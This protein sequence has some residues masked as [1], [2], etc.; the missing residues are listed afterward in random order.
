MVAISCCSVLSWYGIIP[1][2]Y[3]GLA[4]CFALSVSGVTGEILRLELGVLRVW[5]F[6]ATCLRCVLVVCVCVVSKIA[7]TWSL[8]T[9]CR[10]FFSWRFGHHEFSAK[11]VTPAF[12]MSGAATQHHQQVSSS[13]EFLG[14]MASIAMDI[15]WMNQVVLPPMISRF[16]GKFIPPQRD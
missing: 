13:H 4:I 9:K 1:N 8:C 15:K 3:C 14:L 2:R 16:Y 5:L 10:P 12:G 11:D 7:S 6:F